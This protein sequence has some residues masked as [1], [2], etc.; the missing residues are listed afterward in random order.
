MKARIAG[1]AMA[2]VIGITMSL[3]A[4]AEPAKTTTADNTKTAYTAEAT[5]KANYTAFAVKADEEGYKSVAVLFRAAA[6]SA[7]L[8]ADRRA[9]AM[10]KQ[11]VKFDAPTVKPEVK[12][13][14]ENLATAAKGTSTDYAAF[15]KQAEGEN[16]AGITIS[17]KG[18]NASEAALVKLFEQA[19]K[20]LVSWKTGDK[21]IL[22]CVVCGYVTTDSAIKLCPVCNSPREKFEPV[23]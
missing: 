23:K 18:A 19:A 13:T 9:E 12:T 5:A 10:K 2:A 14:A 17:F 3:N 1:I 11:G 21:A 16:D 8:H 20:E 7:G 22:I 15:A 4:A 6:K